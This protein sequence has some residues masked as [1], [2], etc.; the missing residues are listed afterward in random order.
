[1]SLFMLLHHHSASSNFFFFIGNP[2]RNLLQYKAG[3][4]TVVIELR[5][6]GVS[7]ISTSLSG[8]TGIVCS[9]LA[10]LH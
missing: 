2:E 1:M 4:V 8:M 6:H 5:Q 10:F 7:A 3:V 9:F